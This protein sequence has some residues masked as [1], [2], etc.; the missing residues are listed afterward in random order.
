MVTRYVD[1]SMPDDTGNGLTPVTAKRTPRAAQQL[2]SPGDQILLRTGY[3]YAPVSGLFL[4]FTGVSNVEVGTYGTASDKPILDALTYQNPGV[5]GWNHVGSGIWKRIFAAFYIRRLWVGS[6]SLGNLVSERIVGTAKRRATGIGLTTPAANPTEA[7]ILAG[8]NS[9]NIWFGGGPATSYALYVYTGSASIDPPVHY[10]GLALLQ[11]DGS[12][13]GSVA[14]IHVQNQTGIYAHDLHF[15]GNG[16]S[17]I[18]IAAQNSDSRDVAN[19][20]FEDCVVTHPYQAAFVSRIAGELN[21]V[22]RCTSTTLRRVYCDYSSHPDEME[23]DTSYNF[24]SG[25]SDLFNLGDGS[26]AITIEECTA[27]NSAHNGIVSGA[28][29]MNTVPPSGCR[30]MNNTVYFD[31]WHTYARGLSA[32]SGD[33]IFT[34]NLVNG[35][36]T[37]SQFAG[38]AKV[39]GNIWINLRPSVRKANVSQWIAVESY[40]YDTFTS[41]VGNERYLRINPVNLV[42]ANNTVYSPLDAAIVFNY[43]YSPLGPANNSFSA[44]AV[45]I[46]NNII[47]SP[48]QKFLITYEETGKTIGPQTISNNCVYTSLTHDNKITWRGVNCAINTAPGCSNNIEADPQLDTDYRPQ[49]AAVKRMGAFVSG[50]DF[51][52]KQFYYPPNIG[53]VDDLSTTGR[54]LLTL[55]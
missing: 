25:I 45:T 8:L 43:Y 11:S 5:A 48:A 40:M 37:R 16:G 31:A 30:V 42:I 28:S 46:Q 35:Q 22:R 10:G 18:R 14:G 15:R 41:G 27:I 2:A 19:C 3:C 33:T 50:K 6:T 12:T 52:G 9:N 29:A 7:Q 17:G 26:V 13:V 38:S 1:A 34:G 53:A 32:F 51:Y 24:L 21:P 55:P 47:H 36:N 20:L 4:F 54:W 49:S 23:L 44:G 39:I